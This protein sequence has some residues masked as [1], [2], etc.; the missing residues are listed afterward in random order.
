MDQTK[1]KIRLANEIRDT[2]IEFQEQRLVEASNQLTKYCHQLSEMTIE[3]G[4]FGKSLEHNWLNAARTT[5]RRIG[6]LLN[7]I[8]Y[9]IQQMKQFTDQDKN[10]IPTLTCIYE[11]LE[12]LQQEFDGLNLNTKEYCQ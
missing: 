8:T 2:L 11:E 4:K 12:Q 7:D 10:E 3:A 5:S 6:L 9:S 1:Q